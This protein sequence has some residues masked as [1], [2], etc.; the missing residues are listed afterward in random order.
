MLLVQFFQF[1]QN[2]NPQTCEQAEADLLVQ[3]LQT[4]V[5]RQLYSRPGR[6]DCAFRKKDLL[7]EL[8][9]LQ[10]STDTGKVDV[11]TDSGRA[12]LK[13]SVEAEYKRQTENRDE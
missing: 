12:L 3:E 11:P 13:V 5:H 7:S 6:A 10:C 8:A 9:R 2:W 1:P 4:Q